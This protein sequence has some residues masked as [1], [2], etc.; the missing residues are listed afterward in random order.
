MQQYQATQ[1][2]FYADYTNARIIIIDRPGGLPDE[3]PQPPNP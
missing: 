2:A 3:E 1:P